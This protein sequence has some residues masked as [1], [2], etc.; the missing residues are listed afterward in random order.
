MDLLV[1]IS[2][3]TIKNTLKVS[4]NPR[5]LTKMVNKIYETFIYQ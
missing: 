1:S 5:M 4:N 2:K 3:T